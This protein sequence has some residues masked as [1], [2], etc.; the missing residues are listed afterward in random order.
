VDDDRILYAPDV[1]GVGRLFMVALSLPEAAE[2]VHVRVPAAVALLGHRPAS[3]S[4]PTPPPRSGEG[5]RSGT[6]A[7]ADG[8]RS[9]A[10]SGSPS[11]LRGGGRGERSTT[12]RLYFRALRPTKTATIRIALPCGGDAKVTVAIWSFDDLRA[13]RTLKGERLPRRWPL[14]EALPELK[15]GQTVTTSAVIAAAKGNP[16]PAPRWLETPDEAIWAMQ[17]DSTLPR[18]HWV[19]IAHGCPIHGTEIYRKQ[20]YYPWEKDLSLPWKWKIRCPVGG[21]EYPS[22]DLGRDD[23]T[24]GDF[25]DDG[26]GG[27]FV[28][29]GR[30]YGFLAEISQAYCHQML[31]V[32]PECAQGYLATGDRRYVHKA[33][34]AFCRLAVEYAYLATMTQHRHRNSVAQVERFGQGRFDEGPCLAN[35]GFTVYHIDQPSYQSRLAEAYDQIFPAIDQEREILSFLRKKGFRVKT[36]ADVRRFIE[37]NLF[38][39]WMQGTMDGACRSNEPFAQRG[40]VRMAEVLNYARGAEFMEWLY[41]GEGKMRVFVTNGFFRDGAPYE[42]TGGYNG[43]HVS[44]LGPIVDGIEHLRALRPE[45]YP[46]AKYPSLSRSRRYRNVFDFDMETVTLDR[47][48]PAIGD[49]GGPPVYQKL[50]RITWQSGGAEAF[51]HAYRLFREPKLAWAL[52]HAPGWQPPPAFPFSREELEREAAKWRDDWND[53]SSLHDGYGV[54]ILRS[55]AGNAKRALWL[56]YGRARGHTQDDLMDL[57]LQAYEGVLLAHMGYPRNWGYWEHSW[58][59]HH[60]ARQIPFTTMTAQA[61]LFADAG[62]V[63]LA[64]AR[65]QGYVDEVDAGHGYRLLPDVWQRRM[66]ALID[67]GPD[68]FYAVD[69]YRI[70]GG[71]EHWWSFPVQEGEFRL[72]G[73]RLTPQEGGTLAGSDVPY[74]DPKWLEANGC[75]HGV[76]GWSGPMFAFAHLYNVQRG[77]PDGVWTADWTLKSGE[78]LHLRV[79]GVCDRATG[80]GAPELIVCDGKSPAGGSPYEMKWLMLRNGS[81]L[82]Q[83]EL[84]RTQV[85]N[86]L[87]AYRGEPVV[88]E[89]R[90]LSI[91]GAE[92]AGFGA[93]GCVAHLSD[94]TDRI[95]IAADASVER[96]VEGGIRFAGRFGFVAEQAGEIVA[97][98]LVCGTLLARGDVSIRLER[99]E[100]RARITAVDRD[101]ETITVSP[102]PPEPARLAGATIFLTN[103]DRRVAYRVVSARAIAG[104]AELRLE[105]DSRIG[106]GRV[107]GT[108]DGRVKTETPFPLHRF[109]YYHGARLVNAAHS[110]EYRIVEVR[111]RTAAILDAA[112]HP[113]ATKARLADEFPVGTWFDVYDYGVGD[114]V[115]WPYVVSVMRMRPGV[116]RVDAPEP[117]EVRLPKGAVQEET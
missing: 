92:E 9:S 34:V 1:V 97:I 59:S 114:E 63:H 91:S 23:F 116:Y 7:A 80:R 78:G 95:L 3:T 70:A 28:A 77:A 15:Q 68:R 11:P 5:G 4:P 111:D 62:P 109:R 29:D 17:P 6:D 94:R 22:N 39:V 19:N 53:Q 84:L 67:A 41:D 79:T 85:V 33:L 16:G 88:R 103:P 61:E 58:S 73:A 47:S 107:T 51:E 98:T 42:S 93:A 25:A 37:E 18:W 115:V 21:E 96:E 57:G 83:G 49:T 90:K 104:G 117:V 35:S 71:E 108:E 54:A 55:G 66:L 100:Y 43:M 31:R 24:S 40:F 105:G 38:A 75:A 86:L 20:P 60:V 27:G 110:V 44:S 52:V 56:R 14:G 89:V 81:R 50:S 13:Y 74:G 106:T 10:G 2:E 102:G 76:Y 99:P 112:V 12:Y 46:E 26:M 72:D 101:T 82:S 69:F 36:P 45:V 48:F 87:E 30:H 113:E 32:A 65:A 64:E 8:K